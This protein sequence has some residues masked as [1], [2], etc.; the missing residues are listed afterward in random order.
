MD[1]SGESQSDLP[2]HL[3]RGQDG[4][5]LAAAYLRR[6]GW[7]IEDTNFETEWGEIDIIATRPFPTGGQMM[8]FVEVKSRS[9]PGKM[10]PELSV[11]AS[12]RRTITRMARYYEQRYGRPNTGYRFDVI[13]VDFSESPP[14]IRHFEAAFDASGNPY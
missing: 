6:K 1:N 4:E 11:T 12:K 10:T 8:A 2:E 3:Q 5:A 13:A 7:K 9:S 14:N